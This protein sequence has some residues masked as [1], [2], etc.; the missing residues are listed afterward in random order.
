MAGTF[1]SSQHC[2][3]GSHLIARL[4]VGNAFS[5]PA[6][7]KE[8]AFL[9][10]KR[11]IKNWTIWWMSTIES[12][13]E[14]ETSKPFKERLISIPFWLKTL[15]SSV[16][17]RFTKGVLPEQYTLA[18]KPTRFNC[19]QTDSETWLVRGGIEK[20]L[21]DTPVPKFLRIHT[22]SH[23][24]SFLLRS[25]SIFQQFGLPCCHLLERGLRPSDCAT[26]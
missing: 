16:V 5:K 12:E 24:R 18:M 26:R 23:V 15:T 7:S 2:L 20:T 8:E 1:G 4:I 10:M 19:V 22:V 13:D 11:H 9:V 3:W 17:M 14:F 21:C 25:C 6:K